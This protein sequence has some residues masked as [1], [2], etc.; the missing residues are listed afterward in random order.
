MITERMH[1]KS[2]A[3]LSIW[4]LSGVKEW[5]S[6]REKEGNGHR[7]KNVVQPDLLICKRVPVWRA[8][9]LNL[10]MY[11]AQIQCVL[12]FKLQMQMANR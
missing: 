2:G 3:H 12:W 5:K 6:E 9:T 4:A 11:I 10:H 1:E 8:T 7:E